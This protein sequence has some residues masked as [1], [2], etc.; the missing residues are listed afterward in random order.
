MNKV[1]IIFISIFII[2]MVEGKI[3]DKKMKKGVVDFCVLVYD[4]DLGLDDFLGIVVIDKEGVFKFS[5]DVF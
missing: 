4:K 1:I 2:Y 5:F 3:I